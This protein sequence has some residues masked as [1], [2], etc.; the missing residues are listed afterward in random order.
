MQHRAHRAVRDQKI[1]LA[2]P[3]EQSLQK[4][5]SSVRKEPCT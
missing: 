1:A 5:S 4:A 3:I 2:E